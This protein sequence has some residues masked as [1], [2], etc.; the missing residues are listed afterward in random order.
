MTR[1]RQR[2]ATDAPTRQPRTPRVR[3]VLLGGS[4]ALAPALILGGEALMPAVDWESNS[5]VVATAIAEPGRWQAGSLVGLFGWMLLVPAAIA[6]AQLVRHRKPGLALAIAAFVSA[7]AMAVVGALMVTYT[8][9]AA[10]AADTAQIVAYFDEAEGLVG[11]NVLFP[12][13]LAGPVGMLLLAFGLW[14]TKAVHLWVPVVLAVSIVI[15]FIDEGRMVGVV[16]LALMAVAFLGLAWQYWTTERPVIDV[17]EP[18]APVTET[19][20]APVTETVT[21]PPEVVGT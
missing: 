4:L 11:F 12:V 14:R 7:G 6:A 13:F 9:V 17:R 16:G 15:T 10:R 18:I 5:D 8:F 3:H 1:L 19:A 2:T 21:H 20:V